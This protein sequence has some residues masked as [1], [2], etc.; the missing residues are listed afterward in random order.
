MKYM[1]SYST[2]S[3]PVW[4]ECDEAEMPSV[5]QAAA[6][7]ERRTGVI[8]VRVMGTAYPPAVRPPDPE[9]TYP[10]QLRFDVV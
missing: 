1:F 8:Q 5:V 3:G 6:G 9:A 10:S 2:D 4:W 7:D